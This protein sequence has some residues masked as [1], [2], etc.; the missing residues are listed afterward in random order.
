MARHVVPGD[1]MEQVEGI[2]VCASCGTEIPIH[3]LV[4]GVAPVGEMFE[5]EIVPCDADKVKLSF[6]Q[7]TCTHAKE[8]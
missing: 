2:I 5:V 8:N 7:M 3:G 4:V 1:L 6:H